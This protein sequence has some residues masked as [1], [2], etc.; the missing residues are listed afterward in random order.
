MLGINIVITMRHDIIV[1]PRDYF[2]A[3]LVVLRQVYKSHHSTPSYQNCKAA[4][5]NFIYVRS[6]AASLQT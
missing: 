6:T 4:T 1:M 3:I 2:N 5:C